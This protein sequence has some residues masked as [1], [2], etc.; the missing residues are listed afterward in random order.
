MAK[1]EMNIEL[2]DTHPE[3]QNIVAVGT[4]KNGLYKLDCVKAL[5]NGTTL[6]ASLMLWHERLANS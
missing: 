3:A 2:N 5:S 6:V 4:L 1:H